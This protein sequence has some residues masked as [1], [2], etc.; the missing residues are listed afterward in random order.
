MEN[1]G[2]AMAQLPAL[3]PGLLLGALAGVGHGI[4]HDRKD[5][6]GPMEGGTFWGAGGLGMVVGGFLWLLVIGE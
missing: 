2:T 5:G 1:L 3:A 6:K 4:Y